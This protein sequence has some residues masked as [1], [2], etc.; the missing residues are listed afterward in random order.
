MLGG[1][2]YQSFGAFLPAPNATYIYQGTRTNFDNFL[3]GTVYSDPTT[4]NARYISFNV[5]AAVAYPV[6]IEI[7]GYNELNQPTKETVSIPSVA[8][9]TLSANKY[10]SMTSMKQVGTQ[11]NPNIQVGYAH[12]QSQLLAT[13]GGTTTHFVKIDTDSGATWSVW[14]FIPTKIIDTAQVA[15]LRAKPDTSLFNQVATTANPIRVDKS[16]GYYWIETSDGQT[17][18]VTWVVGVKMLVI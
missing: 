6:T 11:Q 8:T 12:G 16:F 2:Y 13:N 4:V 5:V 14:G 3:V 10:I 7:I 18:D 15:K 17:E 1:T 9:P